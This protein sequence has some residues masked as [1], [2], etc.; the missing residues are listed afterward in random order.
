MDGSSPAQLQGSMHSSIDHHKQMHDT[1]QHADVGVMCL[2]FHPQHPNL[3]ALG[4]YDGSVSVFDVRKGGQPLYTSTAATGKHTDPVWEIFWQVQL[5]VHMLN[6]GWLDHP[7]SKLGWVAG[8]P[9]PAPEQ[10][11]LGLSPGHTGT[12]SVHRQEQHIPLWQGLALCALPA[13]RACVPKLELTSILTERRIFCH[14][15]STFCQLELLSF[16]AV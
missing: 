7:V 3:L 1:D 13:T 15:G 12:A 8:N 2:N 14:G 10:Q 16:A 9:H 11:T 6:D 4:C 5:P